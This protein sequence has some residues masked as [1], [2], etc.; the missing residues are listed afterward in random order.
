M[1]K[2]YALPIA[3]KYWKPG[4]KYLNCIVEAVEKRVA[5]GDFVVVS[6]KALST[7][8]GNII[9]ESGVR[10]GFNAKLISGIWMRIG[11][12]HCLSAL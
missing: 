5:D 2:Y 9:D 6:E 7:A 3:T 4:E 1:T 11:W 12:R 10:P 8:L